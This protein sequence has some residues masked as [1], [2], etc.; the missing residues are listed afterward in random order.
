MTPLARELLEDLY[1]VFYLQPV[2]GVHGL[3][4]STVPGEDEQRYAVHF[5]RGLMQHCKFFEVTA[6]KDLISDLAAKMY[7]SF[8][9]YD[10]VDQRL[11]FL[12]A[13]ISWIEFE[14]PTMSHLGN[15]TDRINMFVA[16]DREQ[17][18]AAPY[19]YRGA[20]IFMGRSD[21]SLNVADRL[22]ITKQT[23]AD[24]TDDYRQ[25]L[26]ESYKRATGAL[27]EVGPRQRVWNIR[28]LLPLPLV[29]SGLKPQRSYE[30]VSSQGEVR[31]FD[32]P[33]GAIQDFVDYATLALI[34]SPRVIGQRGHYPHGRTERD[35][36]KKLKLVGKFP[37]RAWTEIML[38][39]T[40]FPRDARREGSKEMHLTG[41]K[42]LHYCRTYLRVRLGQLEYIEGHWRGNP[43]LGMKQSRYRLEKGKQA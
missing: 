6:V 17:I 5:L 29:G 7:D 24:H 11:A 22:I 18:E 36:L 25:K 14:T 38:E 42:C 13:P 26:A 32:R 16:M 19:T 23:G 33:T 9:E 31:Q 1:G 15:K 8:E 30:H 28:R 21:S 20:F 2:R 3:F 43:A 34:N 41:E 27:T 10:R 39:V 37:L 4:S 35:L 12:P 40:P